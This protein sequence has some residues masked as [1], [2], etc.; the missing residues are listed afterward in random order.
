MFN[1]CFST[2]NPENR[3]LSNRLL[4]ITALWCTA[5][6]VLVY[7][8]LSSF[9]FPAHFEVKIQYTS[10]NPGEQSIDRS[11]A[12]PQE[13]ESYERKE[14]KP[15]ESPTAELPPTETH[16]T[17]ESEVKFPSLD[18]SD[19]PTIE[20]NIETKEEETHSEQLLE[21]VVKSPSLETQDSQTVEQNIERKEEETQLEQLSEAI[22]ESPVLETQDSQPI[23]QNTEA[24]PASPF[25]WNTVSWSELEARAAVTSPSTSCNE[26]QPG[27]L[28]FMPKSDQSLITWPGPR[29]GDN[30]ICKFNTI[31]WSFHLPHMMQSIYGCWSLWE[32]RGGHPVLAGPVDHAG[33]DKPL[34]DR[35]MVG[36]FQAMVDVFNVTITTVDQLSEAELE[37]AVKPPIWEGDW[38]WTSF[39][40]RRYVAWKWTEALLRSE[41]IER[42]S[43]NSVVRIGIIN[44]EA[45]Y[46]RSILNAQDIMEQL[47]RVFGDKVQ[48]NEVY[49]ED[50]SFQEQLQWFSSHDIVLTGHGAQETGM[51]FM[52]KCGVLLEVFPFNYYIPEYF[53][54]L[55]DST[56]VRHYVINNDAT[57]SDPQAATKESSSN[58]ETEGQAKATKL[59]PATRST[60]EY[61]LTAVRDWDSCCRSLNQ[62]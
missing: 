41:Q 46:G 43:C 5:T 7:T 35:F 16:D 17:P 60:V 54:A 10:Y 57:H 27:E 49:F 38:M 45:H 25:F 32:E 18:T 61:L 8:R 30:T 29:D 36:L 42:K 48:V 20:K 11:P 23:G 58:P 40:M 2:T 9:G 53:S 47:K 26:T 34:K 33:F 51:P 24:E 12:S 56:D 21:A 52:P 39:Y 37:R 4:W 3:F 6:L 14:E 31:P 55:T 50:T 44:R 62:R 59:C 15:P 22:I 1:H 13:T 28:T 19:S